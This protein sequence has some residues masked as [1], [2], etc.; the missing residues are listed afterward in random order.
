MK[1]FAIVNAI[2]KNSAGHLLSSSVISW[3]QYRFRIASDTTSLLLDL[4]NKKNA[5]MT[6]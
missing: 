5:S 1:N 4:I 2:D 6:C 3:K